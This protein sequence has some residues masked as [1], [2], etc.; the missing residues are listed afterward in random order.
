MTQILR[1]E[2]LGPFSSEI[3]G[4]MGLLNDMSIGK[5]DPS[6]AAT[7]LDGAK[8]I[9]DTSA[10][11]LVIQKL[12]YDEQCL[13]AYLSKLDSYTIRLTRQKQEWIHKKMDR[14]K[15]SVYKW[16]DSKVRMLK[17]QCIMLF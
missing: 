7:D 2:D 3:P 4:V 5:K 17:S 8:H 15:T 16:F 1:T 11:R 9:L 14:A 10:M 6:L 12:E 13:D